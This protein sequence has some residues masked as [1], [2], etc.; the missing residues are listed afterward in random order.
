MFTATGFDTTLCAAACSAQSAYNLRHPPANGPAQTCQF[1]NTYAMYKNDVYQGQYWYIH[2]FPIDIEFLL[3]A[4]SSLYNQ[5]WDMTYATNTGQF[6]GADHYTIQD[7]YIASNS[8]NPGVCPQ[9][10]VKIPL[11]LTKTIFNH[12]DNVNIVTKGETNLATIT[13]RGGGNTG[14]GVST[15][16]FFP[17]IANEIYE[18]SFDYLQQVQDANKGRYFIE[19]GDGVPDDW[20]YEAT[21]FWT[22]VAGAKLTPV[23]YYPQAI[24]GPA[25]YEMNACWNSNVVPQ[26]APVSGVWNSGKVI[27]KPRTNSGY[28][29]WDYSEELSLPNSLQWKNVYVTK[30]AA[31][32]CKAGS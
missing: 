23:S 3:T 4:T 25:G 12:A 22:Q 20:H 6:R 17:A 18:I 9:A 27:L 11:D 14:L 28:F 21:L 32:Y 29:R 19:V 8:S 2:K 15:Q 5:T 10:P 26:T 31:D 13:F 16:I 24:G 7:S 30:M 1:Y